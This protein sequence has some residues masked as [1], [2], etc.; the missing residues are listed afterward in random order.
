MVVTGGR[1]ER[2]HGDGRRRQ[3][4]P[5]Q[6]VLEASFFNFSR[7]RLLEIRMNEGRPCLQMWRGVRVS[8]SL[9]SISQI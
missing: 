8:F 1:T 3:R 5:G 9:I 2:R 7:M 6:F 4:P